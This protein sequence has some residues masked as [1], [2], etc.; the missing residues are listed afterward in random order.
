MV[1]HHPLSISSVAT[2]LTRCLLDSHPAER[3][4]SR[5]FLEHVE[6]NFPTQVA[7]EPTRRVVPGDPLFANR[8]AL[9]GD[10]VA[11]GL[12]GYSDCDRISFK[13]SVKWGRT[14]GGQENH[15]LGIV[16]DRLRS[17]QTTG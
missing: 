12:L 9:V 15:C 10:E 7:G 4:H 2:S 11:K 16:E 13:Y 17:V 1:P 8:G 3:R 14:E 6:Q 5:R